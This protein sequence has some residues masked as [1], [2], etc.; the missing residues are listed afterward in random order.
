MLKFLSLGMTVAAFALAASPLHAQQQEA[1]LLKV[2]IPGQGFDLV[3]AMTKPDG[4][5]SDLRG[6]PDPL[7]IYSGDGELAFAI[8]DKTLDMFKDVSAM[9]A[10]ACTFRTV[11]AAGKSTPVSIYVVPKSEEPGTVGMASLDPVQPESSMHKL[12][13]PGTS[14]DIVYSTTMTP[15]AVSAGE[16]SGSLAVYPAGGEFAMAVDSDIARIFK[17]VGHSEIPDCALDIEHKGSKPLQAASVYVF[18]KN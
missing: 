15:I 16:P 12:E 1:K 10:P 9:S 13:V 4:A 7:V 11:T 14:L 2:E 8:D 5:T 6:V 18:S 17:D 3:F